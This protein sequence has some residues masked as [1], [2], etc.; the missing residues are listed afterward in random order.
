MWLPYFVVDDL[1]QAIQRVEQSGGHCVTIEKCMGNSRY[2]VVA[3]PA[4]AMSVLYQQ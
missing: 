1:A 3:D 4:G 2:R